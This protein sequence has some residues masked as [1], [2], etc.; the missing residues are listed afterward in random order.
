MKTFKM[1]IVIFITMGFIFSQQV[2]GAGGMSTDTKQ[3]IQKAT[4]SKKVTISKSK[5]VRSSMKKKQPRPV[6]KGPG[7]PDL[8]ASITNIIPGPTG[9]ITVQGR[10]TNIGSGDFISGRGQAAGQ[11]VVHLNGVSGPASLLYLDNDPILRLN[12]HQS[13]NLTGTYRVPEFR[14][15]GHETLEDGECEAELDVEFIVWV[16]LDPDIM[17]DGNEDNDDCNYSNNE[18]RR[19]SMTMPAVRDYK[20]PCLL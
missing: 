11:I 20:I 17:D 7:D 10:I 19:Q 2:F 15:W 16:A 13:M 4:S 9:V 6:P 5:Q 12:A 3:T 18:T 1:A 8:M 14:G